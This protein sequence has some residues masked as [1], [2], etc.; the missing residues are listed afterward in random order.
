VAVRYNF[1]GSSGA[2]SLTTSD[3]FATIVFTANPIQIIT[4]DSGGAQLAC[5]GFGTCN[6]Q[7]GTT[8]Y[9]FDFETL[10]GGVT[11]PGTQWTYNAAPIGTSP[12]P[13][14]VAWTPGSPCSSGCTLQVTVAGV[15]RQMP[16]TIS[17][18]GPPTGLSF[19]TVTPC[20]L[21]DTRNPSGPLAGPALVAG[22]NR[23]LTAAGQC[24]IPATARALS[25]N[26]TVTQ[27]GAAGDLR[28]F[29]GGS[30][31]PLVSTINYRAGQSRANNA[32]AALGAAGDLTVLCD[33]GAG[34]VQLIL[35]VNGYFQ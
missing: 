26:V 29:P 11:H 33:Q 8:Y 34:T 25:L 16:I 9:L 32:V 18:S 31:V 27:P 14:P 5:A 13:G 24:G 23:T 4:L 2:Q 28:F 17:G 15:S 21:F 20:R 30:V 22:A 6:L 3:P 35:D 1:T 12:G 19:Y 7:T 10:P